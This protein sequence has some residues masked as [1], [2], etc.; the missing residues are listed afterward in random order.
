MTSLDP[1]W[2]TNVPL[3]PAGTA[4]AF[5][6]S[7]PLTACGSATALT[8]SEGTEVSTSTIGHNDA[9]AELASDMVDHHPQA[10]AMVDATMGRDLDP[11]VAAIAEDIRAAQA[12]EIETMVDWLTKWGEDIPETVR[13]HVNSHHGMEHMDSDDRE[14]TGMDMPG[15]M[16]ADD[17]KSLDTAKDADFQDRWLEMM[18]VH[19]RGAVDLA[20]AQQ[21]N[22]QFKPAVELAEEI[23]AT[24]TAEFETMQGRLS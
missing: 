1:R 15:M 9:D 7:L 18:V 16:S 10:L 22:G 14:D 24:Q 4:V 20:A 2:R 11:E 6:V 17:M 13:D 12:P 21:E 23:E 19:H 3:S 5:S 8:A